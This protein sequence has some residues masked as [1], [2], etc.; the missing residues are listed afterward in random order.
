MLLEIG[1]TQHHGRDWRYPA[2]QDALWNGLQ[3]F[4]SRNLQPEEYS[5]D[6]EQVTLAVADGV[7]SSPQAQRA[8]RLGLD[9]LAEA[10]TAGAAFDVRLVRRL[11]GRLCD[12][13]AKGETFGS[14][15]T[16]AAIQAQGERCVILNVGD[17]RV[18]RICAS[19]QWQQLSHDH[20]VLN[21]MIARGEA[22]AD[23]ELSLIHI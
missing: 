11:Q 12:A 16:F 5:S 18:Y 23:Q 14:A 9:A 20:T 17:S 8:S 4:Q 10:I 22:E 21:G 1:Y 19:G 13:L 2:Q 6:S 7:G 3:V 15:T